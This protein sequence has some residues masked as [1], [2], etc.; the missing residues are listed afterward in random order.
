MTLQELVDRWKASQA[1]EK[2]NAQSFIGDL[3]DALGVE[4]PRPATGGDGDDYVYERPVRLPHEERATLASAWRA[5]PER[6]P[7]G[8]PVPPLLPTEA[9]INRPRQLAEPAP[10]P[11]SIDGVPAALQAALVMGGITIA[12]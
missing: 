10:Q 2:A 12:Q 1:S 3:C 9:W 4:R 7:R 8:K 6:F 5:H 11:P